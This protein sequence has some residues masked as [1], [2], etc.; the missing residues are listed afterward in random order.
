MDGAVMTIEL[1]IRAVPGLERGDLE[2][3]VTHEWVRPD[4]DDDTLLFHEIDVAR[5]R[6]I[7]ELSVDLKVN[8]EALPIVLSLLDQLYE[9]RRRMR[10]LT[11]AIAIAPEEARRAL[12][13]CIEP[14]NPS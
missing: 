7:H 1:V 3:W 11:E 12:L 10:V 8:E 13:D 6:L 14:P 5:V 2:R 4:R 9:T